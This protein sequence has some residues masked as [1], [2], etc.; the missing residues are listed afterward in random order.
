MR[1]ITTYDSVLEAERAFVREM[2]VGPVV[3]ASSIYVSSISV[4]QGG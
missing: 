4:T 2:L 3:P 1:H